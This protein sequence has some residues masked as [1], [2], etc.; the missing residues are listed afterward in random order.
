MFTKAA[1][2]LQTG[3]LNLASKTCAKV[4]ELHAQLV[5]ELGLVNQVYWEVPVE[6]RE[7]RLSLVPTV[8]KI[9]E[10]VG[11]L[12]KNRKFLINKYPSMV[13][14][15]ISVQSRALITGTRQEIVEE[16][17][18][19]E[20]RAEA[21]S[22][23]SSESSE[24]S[25]DKSSG[26]ESGYSSDSESEV[27]L[28]K[29]SNKKPGKKANKAKRQSSKK[30]KRVIE[31]DSADEPDTDEARDGGDQEQDPLP[32]EP[33]HAEIGVPEPADLQTQADDKKTTDEVTTGEHKS[34]VAEENTILQLAT[35]EDDFEENISVV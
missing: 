35:A 19:Y 29:K 16:E 20:V 15:K 23:E 22:S 12:F 1:N 34:P 31:S 24:S 11:L 25:S 7:L 14:I 18:K 9:S 10:N 26:S 33:K 30:E 3:L 5:A 21:N 13:L 2:I 32:A 8:K 27:E 4:S 17:V 28:T 6:N